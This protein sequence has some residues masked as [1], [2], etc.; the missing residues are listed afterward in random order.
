MTANTDPFSSRAA[1]AV[2]GTAGL[3]TVSCR[4]VQDTSRPAIVR[5]SGAPAADSSLM[6]NIP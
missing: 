2:V 4:P 6:K 1:A 5:N 3:A